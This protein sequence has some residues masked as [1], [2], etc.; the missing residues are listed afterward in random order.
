VPRKSW[1]CCCRRAGKTT[2]DRGGPGR[3]KTPDQGA[4]IS[5]LHF[6]GRALRKLYWRRRWVQ[7]AL[8][9]AR[10]LLGKELRHVIPKGCHTDSEKRLKHTRQSEHDLEAKRARARAL[11]RHHAECFRCCKAIGP[12]ELVYLLQTYVYR[13]WRWRV[14]RF[15]PYCQACY[16]AEVGE[17]LTKLPISRFGRTCPHCHRPFVYPV[18]RVDELRSSGWR[19]GRCRKF[20]CYRC[21]VGYHKAQRAA[22][23]RSARNKVCS[24]CGEQFTA[25]RSHALTCSPACRKKAYRARKLSHA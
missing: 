17:G 14:Y 15:L 8:P 7:A 24:A 5:S 11:E 2:G 3:R 22:A 13:N 19:G 12:R 21:A 1:S 25:T 16:R 9:D 10:P 4:Y 23:M 18:L 6:P 20:C